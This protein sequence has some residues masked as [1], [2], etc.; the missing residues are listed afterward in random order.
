MPKLKDER[1]PEV[2]LG[3]GERI[4][5]QGQPAALL[6]IPARPAHMVVT[7]SSAFGFWAY[8]IMVPELPLLR[9]AL[10]FPIF[11]LLAMAAYP[12]LIA[13]ARAR[14][15]FRSA[16]YTLTNQRA[17]SA[18]SEKTTE[19]PVSKTTTSY[20]TP[21]SALVLWNTGT[22]GQ[23]KS[24]YFHQ[25]ENVDAPHAVMEGIRNGVY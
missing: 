2:T 20:I 9:V 21:K 25:L 24:V 12:W 4:L 8:W 23:R 6:K 19:I 11:I 22:G 18:H 10:L 1:I 13:R 17:I 16:R 5:W 15:F 7:L 14:A 3:P